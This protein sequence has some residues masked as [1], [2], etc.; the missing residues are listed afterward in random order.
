MLLRAYF[1]LGIV[2][3]IKSISIRNYYENY[4]YISIFIYVYINIK[5][6]HFAVYQKHNIVNQPYF[7]FKKIRKLSNVF[8]LIFDIMVHKMRNMHA[9]RLIYA[10]SLAKFDPHYK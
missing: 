1:L 10:Q 6:N 5:L 2:P 3:G 8:W 7:S 9:E 4:Y